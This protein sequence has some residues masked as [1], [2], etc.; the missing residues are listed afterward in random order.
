[1]GR[2]AWS[3]FRFR[4]VWLPAADV[5]KPGRQLYRVSTT[6]ASAS[7][8]TRVPQPASYVYVTPDRV[9]FTGAGLGLAGA[10]TFAGKLTPLVLA[11]A[12]AAA[13]AGVL[14]TCVAAPLPAHLLRRL[15][16]AQLL[17]Q[18]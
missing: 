16:A 13:V 4:P 3:Q 1:V 10:A 17:A 9:H 6:W 7:G 11:A 12:A 5:A 8:A 18:E 14:V 15:P 2:L